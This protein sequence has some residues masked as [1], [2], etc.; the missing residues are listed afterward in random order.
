LRQKVQMGVII[1]SRAGGLRIPLPGDRAVHL[2]GGGSVSIGSDLCGTRAGLGPRVSMQILGQ[3]QIAG[4]QYDVGV[5]LPPVSPV[6]LLGV[7]PPTLDQTGVYFSKSG[8]TLMNV[9]QSF[10]TMT[11]N[12][13][14]IP[15]VFNAFAVNH[16]RLCFAPTA[17]IEFFSS[18]GGSITCSQGLQTSVSFHVLGMTVSGDLSAIINRDGPRTFGDLSSSLDLQN[19]HALASNLASAMRSVLMAVVPGDN[20]IVQGIFERAINGVLNN[21]QVNRAYVSIGLGLSI[22]IYA[23]FEVN[24]IGRVGSRDVDFSFG[25]LPRWDQAG[26]SV[27]H[28]IGSLL[29][30]ISIRDIASKIGLDLGGAQICTPQHCTQRRCWTT[31]QRCTEWGCIGGNER[32]VDPVCVPPV[33]ICRNNPFNAAAHS[34]V[35]AADANAWAGHVEHLFNESNGE[36]AENFPSFTNLCNDHGNDT[37]KQV[38]TELEV[39]QVLYSVLSLGMGH[40]RGHSHPDEVA[41]ADAESKE[42]FHEIGSILHT[43]GASSN[44]ERAL[45][46]ATWAAKKHAVLAH[47]KNFVVRKSTDHARRVAMHAA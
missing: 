3:F 34:V 1:P 13:F 45:S 31:P 9:M 24:L 41:T 25:P 37:H 23:T 8:A 43:L 4:Q 42:I 46:R 44:S 2:N 39:V 10:L 30:S 27:T 19:P 7:L 47:V 35:M 29:R 12:D 38:L 5:S 6:S 22:P 16:F 26:M 32:C 18:N 28:Q 11:G 33:R 21:V 14:T 15:E 17:P 20:S 40:S 36:L